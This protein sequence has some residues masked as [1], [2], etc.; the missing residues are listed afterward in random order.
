MDEQDGKVCHV[1]IRQGSL[2]ARRERPS[3]GHQQVTTIENGFSRQ[4]FLR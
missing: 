3:Q 2:E 4:Y 1:E